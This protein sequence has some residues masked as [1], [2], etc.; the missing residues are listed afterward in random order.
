VAIGFEL[1]LRISWYI[2]P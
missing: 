2:T 1:P